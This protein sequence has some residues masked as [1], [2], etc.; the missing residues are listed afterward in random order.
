VGAERHDKPSSLA[1]KSPEPRLGVAG[2]GGDILKEQD[3]APAEVD[4]EE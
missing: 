4:S 1:K 3:V 2:K